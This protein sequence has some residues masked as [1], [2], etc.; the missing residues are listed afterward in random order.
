MSPMT[1]T[2]PPMTFPR[3]H[4]AKMLLTNSVTLIFGGNVTNGPPSLTMTSPFE[5]HVNSSTRSGNEV[6]VLRM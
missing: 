6:I 3:L 4:L 2:Y 5:S 1:Q